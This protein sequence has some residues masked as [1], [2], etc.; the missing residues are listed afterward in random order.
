MKHLLA[1]FSSVE[2]MMPTARLFPRFIKPPLLNSQQRRSLA[3][4]T[5]PA[6]ETRR[7]HCSNNNSR[8]LKTLPTRAPSQAEW[9]R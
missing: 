4:S 3:N 8:I 6:V 9:L 1:A 2:V 5:T 7:A